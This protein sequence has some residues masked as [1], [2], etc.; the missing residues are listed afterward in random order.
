MSHKDRHKMARRS[1]SV[2]EV[3]LVGLADTLVIN[4]LIVATVIALFVAYLGLNNA[5]AARGFEIRETE[6]RISELKEQKK[7]LDLEVVEH[8]AMRNIESQ[9]SALGL[10]PVSSVDYVGIGPASVAVR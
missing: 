8:K 1:A 10:V 3:G 4:M 9:V 2:G 6:H 7:R 5:A